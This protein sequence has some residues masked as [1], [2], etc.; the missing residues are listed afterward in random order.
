VA[1]SHA[2]ATIV[3]VNLN[4]ADLRR[5]AADAAL[6]VSPYLHVIGVVLSA[7]G[8]EYAEVLVTIEGVGHETHRVAVGVRRKPPLAELREQ[9]V[10]KLRQHYLAFS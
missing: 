7:S 9:L 10:A 2:A 8:S 1:E 6:E 4:I 3:R 5:I